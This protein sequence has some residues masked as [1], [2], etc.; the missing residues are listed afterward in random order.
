M[1]SSF[2][3]SGMK[4]D[5][6]NALPANSDLKY[7]HYKNYKIDVIQGKTLIYLVEFLEISIFLPKFD[8]KIKV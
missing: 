5:V 2:Q 7:I 6:G 3:Y 4:C 8:P 1:G